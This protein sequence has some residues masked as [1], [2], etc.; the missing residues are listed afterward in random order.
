MS[1]QARVQKIYKAD[2][3]FFFGGSLFCMLIGAKICD[4]IFYDENKLLK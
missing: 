4:Y 1:I 3:I 2:N